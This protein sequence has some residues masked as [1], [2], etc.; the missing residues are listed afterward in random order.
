MKIDSSGVRNLKPIIKR[1]TTKE[2]VYEQLKTEILSGNIGHEKI[3]TETSLA[4]SLHISRT[5]VR[6]A[7]SDLTKEGLLVHFPRKGFMVRRI[8]EHEMEQI[9]Y[10]RRAIEKRSMKMLVKHINEEDLNILDKVIAEQKEAINNNDRIRYIEL[11]Q[12]F[13]RKLLKMSNQNILENILQELYNLTLLIGHTAISNEGRMEEVIKEHGAIL[14]ALRKGRKE[15]ASLLME[16]H[17]VATGESVQKK[18][19]L[20]IQKIEEE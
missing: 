18:M 9:L 15:E 2:M 20:D 3:M 13:H 6:E 17:L 11:D 1:K 7:V 14:E 8:N 12:T 10:L 5:P 19:Q 16:R 4:E